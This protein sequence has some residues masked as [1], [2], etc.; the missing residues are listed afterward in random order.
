MKCYLLFLLMLSAALPASGQEQTDYYKLP[1]QQQH[2]KR[3]LTRYGGAYIR[4]RWYVSLDGFVRTDRAKLDNS[5]NGLI[6][7]DRVTKAG[8]SGLIG[9]AYRERWAVEAGYTN[10]PTHTEV[11]IN[12]GMYPYTFRFANDKRGLVLRGKH[13]ILSTSGPWRRS[14][15]WLTG[16]LW[17]MPNTS[18]DGGRFALSGY[19]YH[20]RHAE[21]GDTI[22]LIG[23]TTVNA[24]PTAMIETGLEYTVRLTDRF[25]MGFSARKLWGL[26]SAVSTTVSYSVN[27]RETQQAQFDGMGNGMTFGLTMRYTYA[28]KRTVAKVLDIQGKRP[29]GIGRIK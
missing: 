5:F 8:W 23:Q 15:F 16:G 2:Y 20:D 4:S 1:D 7:S 11:L 28:I 14:G 6:A 27:S 9:W 13:M 12:S 10:S 22:R 24:A 3:V 25:D 26:S 17:L 21:K 18:R 19:G 29:A